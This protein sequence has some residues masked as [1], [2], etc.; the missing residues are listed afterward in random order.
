MT[1]LH[2]LPT[3]RFFMWLFQLTVCWLVMLYHSPCH[4]SEL[5]LLGSIELCHLLL[6]LLSVKP[7]DLM[8][9]LSVGCFLF[10]TLGPLESAKH[11]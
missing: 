4:H 5:D 7:P 9:S 8:G 10:M 11:L 2:T 1:N 6:L 3:I